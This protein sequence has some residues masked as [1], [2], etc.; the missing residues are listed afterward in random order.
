MENENVKE[1]TNKWFNKLC[2]LVIDKKPELTGER[3]N[4]ISN[5]AFNLSVEK[6]IKEIKESITFRLKFEY[7]EKMVTLFVPKGSE[8]LYEIIKKHFSNLGYKTFYID[9]NNTKELKDNKYLFISWDLS[10]EQLNKT[11]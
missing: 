10:E 6:R 8:D 4:N 3:A 7:P 2:A 9:K 1:K 5:N 11:I